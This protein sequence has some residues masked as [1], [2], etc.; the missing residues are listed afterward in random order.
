MS[1]LLFLSW[2]SRKKN[3]TNEK[4]SR[5]AAGVLRSGEETPRRGGGPRSGEGSPRRSK[6][7]KEGWPGLGFAVAKL[8]FAAAKQCFTAAKQCFTA[9]K[10][11][12]TA[13][14]CCVFV[15]FFFFC[16][17]KDLSIGLIRTL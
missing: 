7:K 11:L 4:T 13:W 17:S 8:S 2:I 1:S 6:A 10:P 9:A 15:S 3:W 12:F 16:C 14:K 5:Q